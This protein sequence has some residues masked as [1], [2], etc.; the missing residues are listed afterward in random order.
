M[1]V[2]ENGIGTGDVAALSEDHAVPIDPNAAS[3]IEVIRG[4]ATL[5]YGSQ[6]IGGVVAVENDRIPSAI[7]KGGFSGEIRGGLSSVDEG[8]DGAFRATAGSNGI[9]VYADGFKRQAED[10]DTPRGRQLNSYVD[11]E[12]GALGVSMVGLSGFL[13]VSI[14]RFESLYGIPGEEGVEEQKRIDLEQD[15][16][17]VRGE[18]RVQDFGVEALPRLVRRIGLRPPGGCGGW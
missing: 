17:Q 3:R 12:G 6:A 10:Y 2:Q 9:A 7:P 11:S 8:R 14:S 16:L 5:R 15:K 18:W 13:G 4:P 1:R